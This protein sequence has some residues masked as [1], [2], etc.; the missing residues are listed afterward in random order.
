MR[1]LGETEP[2]QDASERRQKVNHRAQ[3]F[4]ALLGAALI[5]TLLSLIPWLTAD[6]SSTYVPKRT[7]P[8]TDVNPYGANFFLSREVEDWKRE[9]TVSMAA[10]AGI[11]WAKE[12][13]S[14]AEIERDGKA[15][16]P[17]DFNWG[18]FDEIVDLCERYGLRIIARLDRAPDWSRK[19]DSVPGSPP[20]DFNDYGDFVYAFVDHYKGRIDYIQIWNEPN[21]WQEWGRRPVDPAGYV[22]LLK[23]AYTRAKEANPN[24]YVLS[25]PLAITLGEPHPEEGKW[26]AM[27]D[28]QY[29]REMYEA[30]AKPYFD[31]L[32]AN[33]FGMEYPPDDPPS[34]DKLNFSRVVLQRRIM[35]E[36]GDGDKA[37]WLNEFG[38]NAP[39]EQIPEEKRIWGT[40]TEEQQAEY[41]L[42]AIEMART[43]WP[44]VGVFNFW[45]FRQ[46]G[47]I[48][49]DS[50]DYYFRMVDVDFT[51]RRVYYTVKDAAS[52]LTIASPGYHEETSPGVEWGRGW[53]NAI[54]REASGG[55]SVIAEEP[56]AT[57]TLTFTG[58][59]VTLVALRDS[60]SGFLY[61]TLDGKQIPGLPTAADGR[62]Y[63]DLYSPEVQWQAQ[64]PVV[65]GLREG[66]HVLR[67]TTSP[68]RNPKAR[69]SRCAIDAFIVEPAGR[70][71]FPTAQVIASLLLAAVSGWALTR[72]LRQ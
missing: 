35:E 45:Y 27:S 7:I 30:G 72:Q 19:D 31:I 15:R 10:E 18:K 24:V 43:Q 12:Q 16:H 62:S 54:L 26:S 39:P 56:D 69:G 17:D 48:L 13:F 1:F 6:V 42:K 33:A 4:A 32:A 23:I 25:A 37:V 22:E 52:S 57:L 44:W 11:R 51:P 71:A 61:A 60:R 68:L 2:V 40:V 46:V 65:S 50:A 66:R 53:Q 49:P 67:L 8:N 5:G 47:D 34:E 64:I 70:P 59:G 55:A 28:L 38:W 3:L 58:G 9:R 29:L 63:I 41:A 20:D 36:Y 14:W 21:L